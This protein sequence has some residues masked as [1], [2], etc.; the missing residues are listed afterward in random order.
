MVQDAVDLDPGAGVLGGI[1]DKIKKTKYDLFSSTTL[2]QNGQQCFP[3][4]VGGVGFAKVVSNPKFPEHDF[5][6]ASRIFCIRLRHNNMAFQDDAMLDGRVT[7]LKFCDS[8]QGGELDLIFATGRVPQFYNTASF[9]V[10]AAAFK[11]GPS[12]LRDWVFKKPIKYVSVA[13]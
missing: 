8:D 7:S 1:G 10:F 12:D 2:S 6:R 5:F 9:E 4:P 11:K 3:R 13:R